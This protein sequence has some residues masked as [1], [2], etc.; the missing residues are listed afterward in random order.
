[1]LPFVVEEVE[2]VE[3]V[4]EVEEVEVV[5]RRARESRRSGSSPAASRCR[6]RGNRPG[7]LICPLQAKFILVP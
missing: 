4:E 7:A 1:V 3:V 5:E 2:V 6:S